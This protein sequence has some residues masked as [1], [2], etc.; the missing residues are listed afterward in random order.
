MP[1]R[2]ASS[3][4]FRVIL[5]V[6]TLSVGLCLAYFWLHRTRNVLDNLTT[7]ERYN[8]RRYPH[9]KRADGGF[10][11]PFDHGPARN[12]AQFFCATCGPDARPRLLVAVDDAWTTQP[13]E[14]RGAPE[15][16]AAGALTPVKPVQRQGT[17]IDD[18]V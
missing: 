7:N 9:F 2:V 12:C 1:W 8:R 17:V 3:A 15:S 11:N 6:A 13:L 10:T 5:A 14:F 18:H 4:S 16:P